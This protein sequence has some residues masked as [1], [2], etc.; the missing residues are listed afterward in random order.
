MTTLR[1]FG[2]PLGLCVVIAAV[3]VYGFAS[4]PDG[5][6]IPTH[7]GLSGH[8]D[9]YSRKTFGLLFPVTMA[10]G[11][12]AFMVALPVIDPRRRNI[13]QSSKATVALTTAFDAFL[14]VI[15][16]V[17]IRSGRGVDGGA[18]RVIPVVVALLLIVFGN[19]MGKLR[20][21]FFVGIRTPWTLSSDRVWA[22]THRLGGR[23]FVFV[24]VVTLAVA[25][26]APS[27]AAAVMIVGI[28]G[29]VA[30]TSVYSYVAFR[31]D[32]AVQSS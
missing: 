6:R 4:V 29:V 11:F 1:R 17:G 21:N 30:V 22:I 20:S 5:A 32:G 19:Y 2:L 14:L 18:D 15:L 31:R 16:I 26:A 13:E 24:G 28:L 8:A 10:I 3:A 27:A 23:L 25:L 12:T 7:W 9:G